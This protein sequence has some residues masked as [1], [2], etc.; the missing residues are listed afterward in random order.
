MD[1]ATFELWVREHGA[2]V[3]RAAQRVLRDRA[4]AEDVAQQVFLAALEGRVAAGDAA[5]AGPAL[6]W[7][8]VKTALF[9]LRTRRRRSAREEAVAMERT[10]LVSEG[11]A[12]R[13]AELAER[14]A[15]VARAVDALPEE[16]RLAVVLRF[17]QGLGFRAIGELCAVAE[18][19]AFERVQRGLARLRGELERRGLAALLPVLPELLQAL[20]ADLPVPTGLEAQLVALSDGAL[21]GGAA[22]GT[23]APALS[24]AAGAPSLAFGAKL[25]LALL[26]LGGFG[27]LW[28]RVLG[29]ESAVDPRL[30]REEA[31]VERSRGEPASTSLVARAPSSTDESAGPRDPR[32]DPT[33]GVAGAA[34]GARL[35]GRLADPEGRF[36]SGA[37]I[38][39]HSLESRG[40]EPRFEV[41]G[42]S[43][44][45]GRFALE[46]PVPSPA[47]RRYEWSIHAA[48]FAT[49]RSPEPVALAAR[50]VVDLGELRLELPIGEIA[51]EAELLL[52]VVDP[53]GAPVRGAEL[54]VYAPRRGSPEEGTGEGGQVQ[55]SDGEG[56]ARFAET[57]L[58]LRH[59]LVR[60]GTQELAAR[61]LALELR[62]GVNE[63]RVELAWGLRLAGRLIAP[64]G[65]PLRGV[66]LVLRQGERS[67][68]WAEI[69][70]EGAFAFGGL[71]EGE[72]VLELSGG[73]RWSDFHLDGV[74]G[75]GASLELPLKPLAETR[76]EGLHDAELHGRV[77]DAASGAE[78]AAE[79]HDLELHAVPPD[80]TREELLA[81][82]GLRWLTPYFGQTAQME[83]APV[84]PSARFVL[85]GIAAGR[86]VL[87][88]VRRGYAPFVSEV[89]HF[90]EREIR[91]DFEIAFRRG[92]ELRGRVHGVDGRPLADAVLFA[93]SVHPEV[94]AAVSAR[95]REVREKGGEGPL[96]FG[97]YVSSDAQGRFT[98]TDVLP[99]LAQQLWVLHPRYAPQAWP[100]RGLADGVVQAELE[101]ELRAL[102]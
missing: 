20:S 47:P 77:L 63:L 27:L 86:Y 18:T 14:R 59:V 48:G 9:H 49:R 92:A 10:E 26:F 40:K 74:R 8:A 53:R 70:P 37:A 91:A 84:E 101:L 88:A 17:E 22:A 28:H 51:G 61:E 75:G 56:L 35:T 7:L 12:V 102:R 32:R 34:D 11:D 31:R 66:Q 25:A 81:R 5:A 43:D 15:E 45:D 94:Q 29:E 90:G 30:P 16:L 13:A 52:R 23:A 54:T 55:R 93:T 100:L 67:V 98:V 78:L 73:R 95:D 76:S 58:G 6:R 71:A 99:E 2:A 36:L 33:A 24:A 62:P 72:H 39:A 57:S 79:E 50:E 65:A 1:R 89:L 80:A 87:V 97:P 19:T 60:P 3:F 42:R 64:D 38:V 46:L 85:D 69:G 68:R 41:R 44:V 83:R 21:G 96:L 4:A 82:E